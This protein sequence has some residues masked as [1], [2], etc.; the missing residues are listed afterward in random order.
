MI[1]RGCVLQAVE[2]RKTDR[3]PARY[4]AVHEVT[5]RLMGRIGVDYEGLLQALEIDMRRVWFVSLLKIS[6]AAKKARLGAQ[7]RGWRRLGPC[8]QRGIA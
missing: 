1:P 2:Q 3:T 6:S 5:Q 8:R 7:L 4:G